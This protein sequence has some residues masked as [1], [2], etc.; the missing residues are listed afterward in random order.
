[1]VCAVSD[2][3][4]EPVPSSDQGSRAVVKCLHKDTAPKDLIQAIAR[5]QV[6]DSINHI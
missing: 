5:E 1:M 6:L 2:S 3:G 4:L